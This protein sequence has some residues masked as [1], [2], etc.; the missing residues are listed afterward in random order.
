MIKGFSGY[1]FPLCVCFGKR[2]KKEEKDS[3]LRLGEGC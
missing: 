2:K 1:L 3:N